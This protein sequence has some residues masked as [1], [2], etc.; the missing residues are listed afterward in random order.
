MAHE[1][2]LICA[3]APNTTLS[4]LKHHTF[5]YLIGVDGGAARLVQA[6]YDLYAA[7]GDFDSVDAATQ[8]LICQKSQHIQRFLSEKD[9][10]DTELALRYVQ[11]QF[12]DCQQVVLIGALSGG[13]MDH[14]LC[15]IWLGLQPRFAPLLQRLMLWDEQNSVRFLTPGQHRLTPEPDKRYVSFIS[16]TPLSALTLSGFKYAVDKAVYDTPRALISNEFAAS[17]GI[18]TFHEGMIIA[19]QS[20]DAR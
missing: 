5:D 10:T 13:R 4:L 2:I 20:R 1:R 9:D 19:I 15:N 18:V 8:Q 11:E 16:T 14:L 3:G 12:P 6:G 7:V 17:E